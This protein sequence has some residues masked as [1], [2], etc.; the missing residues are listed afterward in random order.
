M[1]RGGKA[2]VGLPMLGEEEE[3]GTFIY[4]GIKSTRCYRHGHAASHSCHRFVSCKSLMP[5]SQYYY[6]ILYMSTH[7]MILVQSKRL[8]GT[9]CC[10]IC[11]IV[12]YVK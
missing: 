12:Y 1:Q 3:A 7:G 8:V 4:H 2:L 6:S 10:K 11:D 5:I 9:T